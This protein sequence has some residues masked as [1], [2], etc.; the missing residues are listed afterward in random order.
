MLESMDQEKAVN[1]AGE[2][3]DRKEN[4]K[5]ELGQLLYGGLKESLV[6]IV[7]V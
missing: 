6:R 4:E 3:G 5:E 2:F 7:R 1:R